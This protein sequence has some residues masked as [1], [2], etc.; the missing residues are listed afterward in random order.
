MERFGKDGESLGWQ[1]NGDHVQ[2]SRLRIETR[3]WILSKALPKIYGD[4]VAVTDSDGGKL[5][6]QFSV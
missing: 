1:L 3:K 4:K 2:R 6:I 5:T